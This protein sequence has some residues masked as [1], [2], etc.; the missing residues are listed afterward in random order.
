VCTHSFLSFFDAQGRAALGRRWRALLAPGGAIVTAQR[1]REGDSRAIARY[2][3]AESAALAEDM[4]RRAREREAET[5]IAPSAARALAEGWTRNYF[6]HV[7]GSE[8]ALRS[9]FEDNG[10]QLEQCAPGSAPGSDRPGTPR[11]HAG[12][13]WRIIARRPAEASA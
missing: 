11:Q 8:A 6:A 12:S 13:R 2:G 7:I 5:A 4:E 9:V 1:I 3:E 10:L